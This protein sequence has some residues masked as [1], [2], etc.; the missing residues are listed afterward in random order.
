MSLPTRLWNPAGGA[1]AGGT[2]P[3]WD[4]STRDAADMVVDLVALLAVAMPD[5]VTFDDYTIFTQPLETD[6]PVPVYSAGLGTAGTDATPGWTQAVQKTFTFYDTTF[7]TAKIVLLDAASNNDFSKH[8]AG[9]LTADEIAIGTLFASVG[10][11]WSSRAG[12]RPAT[13]LSV[14]RTLNETLRRKY[15]AA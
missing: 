10:E 8:P 4:T 6:F 9:S 15:R 12:F 7:A 14:T 2:F 11:A 1:G 13:L 3:A 5:S